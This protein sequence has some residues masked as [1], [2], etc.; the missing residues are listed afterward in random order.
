MKKENILKLVKESKKLL[1]NAT[2]EQKQRILKML[3]SIKD[4]M[5]SS[6]ELKMDKSP[7]PVSLN[8][9]D[10]LQEK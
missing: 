2:T 3:E 1:P 6:K 8:E 4:K 5:N 10:Y 7:G 9:S